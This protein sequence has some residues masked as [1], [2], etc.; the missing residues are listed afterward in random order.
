MSGAVDRLA[1]ERTRLANERTW[2]AY[3]RTALGFGGAGATL[4][5]LVPDDASDHLLGGAL[6]GLG[7]LLLVVGTWRCT[8]EHL[9]YVRLEAE[10]G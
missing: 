2:L 8:R 3:L 6:L 9:R 7:A 5:R 10:L 1:L 4:W